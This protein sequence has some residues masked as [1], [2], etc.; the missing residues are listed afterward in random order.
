MEILPPQTQLPD[1]PTNRRHSPRRSAGNTGYQRYRNCLRWEFGFACAFCL[2]HEADFADPQGLRG[3]GSMTVEHRILRKDDPER[4]NDYSNCYLA[5]R[6]CNRARG[7]KPVSQHGAELLDPSVVPWSRHFKLEE[8]HLHPIP[9]DRD[10]A[11]THAA[12]NL[13]DPIKVELRRFRRELYESHTRFIRETG[14]GIAW[15]WA[16][17]RELRRRDR[18]EEVKRFLQV[19][20]SLEQGRRN[21]WLDLS[22]FKAVSQDAPT[23]CSC[24]PEIPRILP[25]PFACQT[26]NLDDPIRPGS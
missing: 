12:Y 8:D 21:A 18:H 5:C 17:I 22:R 4:S 13:D 19:M 16:W 14:D 10:A 24:E 15:L 20:R 3:S 7:I 2:L 26:L 11:Y 6:Y 25:A 9:G 1:S 23:S